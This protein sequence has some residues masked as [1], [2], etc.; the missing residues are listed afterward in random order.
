MILL[1]EDDIHTRRG[2]GTV[3]RVNGFEVLE[4]GDASQ[5][6]ALLSEWTVDLIIADLLLPDTNGLELVDM[7]HGKYPKTPLIAISGYF[8]Q[9]VGTAIL[10]E[11]AKFFQKPIDTGV[12]I[13]TVR[14]LLSVSDSPRPQ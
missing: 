9:S 1:I 11:T 13:A 12:L 10:A 14:Q 3:L 6:L 4:A 7:L 5:A 8:T 2:Y